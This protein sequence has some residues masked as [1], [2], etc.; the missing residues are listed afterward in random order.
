MS[1]D[2]SRL[3]APRGRTVVAIVVACALGSFAWA[4]PG[5]VRVPLSWP[6]IDIGV[7]GQK[8]ATFAAPQAQWLS[9][10]GEPAIPWH[11]V[12]VLLPP[13]AAI[14]T[15][16][17]EFIDAQQEAIPGTWTV[18]PTPPC[19][20]WKDGAPQIV[21]PDDR[22]LVAGRDSAIYGKSGWWPEEDVRLLTA[23]RMRKWRLV[24]AA[25]PL[26]KYDPTSGALLRCTGGTLVVRFDLLNTIKTLSAVE[27]AERVDSIGEQTVR[28]LALNYADFA[29]TYRVA[30]T[31]R[32]EAAPGYVIITTA[33]IQS[34][35]TKLAD[36]VATKQ[37][38]GFAVSVITETTWGGGTGNTAA[39][40]I[41]T[42]LASHYATDHVEY[43]LL[44]GH[45]HPTTGTVPMKMLWPRQN[46]SSDRESPSDLYYAD[47]TGNWDLDG[48]G[49]YGEFSGDFGAGG[50]DRFWEVIVGRIPN[51]GTISELDGILQK[52]IDYQ[53]QPASATAWRRSALLPMKA[54]DELTPGYPLGEQLKNSILAP[55]GW[56]YHR[57]YDDAYNLVPPPETTPCTRPNVTN[58]WKAG[59]FGL[60]AWWTHGSSTSAT[61]VMDTS[62]AAQLTDD[63]PA[64]AFQGS[65]HNGYPDTSINLAYTLLKKG[66]IST[67]AAS[68]V[69]WYTV[70]ETDYR[71]KPS[72]GGFTYEYA[73][74]LVNENAAAGNA[75][76]DL[77]R[78][79]SP[80][81]RELWMNYTDFNLYGDPAGRMQPRCGRRYVK[82]DAPAG[83][84]G[85]SWPSAYRDLQDALR[86]GAREI[87]VAAGTYKPDRG[88]GTRTAA[89]YLSYETTLYGGFAGTESSLAERNAQYNITILS[90]DLA[91]DDEPNYVNNAENSYNVVICRGAD[92]RTVLDG[93][94]IADG[95]ANGSYWLYMSGAG[96]YVYS[97]S[98]PTVRACR[99]VAN[100]ANSYGAG[101]FN[102]N[103]STPAYSNCTF[104]GNYAGV[105]GGGTS[106]H[107]GSRAVFV[108]CTFTNN[109]SP[110]G[111]GACHISDTGSHTRSVFAG[112]YATNAGGAV[113]CYGT[114]AQFVNCRLVGNSAYSLG[115]AFSNE[116][117][118][119]LFAN[120]LFNGNSARNG[121]GAVYTAGTG[122]NPRFVNCTFT[123]NAATLSNAQGGGIR[124]SDAARVSTSTNCI[125]WNN[126]DRDGTGQS[127]QISNGVPVVNH[128]CVMGWTGSL[129]GVGNFGSDP[130]LADLDGPD[131]LAGTDD[132]DLR[133]RAASPCLDAGDNTALPADALDLDADGD[134]TEPLPLDL[135]DAARCS[136]DPTMPD[137]GNGMPPLVDIGAYE[138]PHQALVVTPPSLAV[139]EGATAAF[140]V[141]IAFDPGQPVVVSIASV[142]GD[143]DIDVQSGA[144]LSFNSA[145]YAVP[146]TVLLA[147]ADDLDNL[148]GTTIFSITADG[149]A[150]ETLIATEQEDDA[151]TNVLYVDANGPGCNN[152]ASWD[153]AYSDLQLALSIAAANPQVTEIRVANGVYRPANVSGN[154]LAT[155]ALQNGLRLRGGYAGYGDAM[156]DARD[157]DSSASVLSGDLAGD[158]DTWFGNRGDNVY[159]VVDASTNDV[160]AVLDGFTIY[161]G[162]AN[163]TAP[164]NVG[165]GVYIDAGSPTLRD[166]MLLRNGGVDG[167]GIM[168]TTGQ[169]L[170]LRCAFVGNWA[171]NNGGGLAFTTLSAPVE[172][173][174]FAGNGAMYGG[175]LYA[176]GACQIVNCAFSGN[177]A[178]AGGGAYLAYADDPG[179]H[180]INC[181]FSR[182]ISGC[183]AYCEWTYTTNCVFWDNAGG[184]EGEREACQINGGYELNY[185]C[186]Q[187]WWPGM[188]GNGNISD[189]PGLVDPDGPDN[190]IGTSD[191]DLRLAAGS[192]CIDA[193][194]N[195]AVPAG[196]T[197]DPDRRPRFVD[198]PAMPNVGSGT[199][200]IVDMGAYEHNPFN[201]ADLN[202]DG[203]VD[204]ADLLLF[205][206][207][208][209]GP[210]VLVTGDCLPRDFSADDDVDLADFALI[211]QALMP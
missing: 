141:R 4:E 119:P 64:M 210:D 159:H 156:P 30:G 165:G 102:D 14:E 42:W 108:D 169:P 91:G 95:N 200:P 121:G 203:V 9:D 100:R 59:A 36:F 28:G 90:G 111:A 112:N 142:S 72:N 62:Y 158:D 168:V 192:P 74:R 172:A 61:D 123:S 23:G 131:G 15:A 155:F 126:R 128:S 149:F 60:V 99:F 32:D 167:A 94:T 194:S 105:Q 139:P 10:V 134:T 6:S 70:G 85:T 197:V 116:A 199:P 103:G 109:T 13:D 45:P 84:D 24:Q 88:T 162:H 16:R 160:T 18:T 152:G 171:D 11:V 129:G 207:C 209:Q 52:T 173:C 163:G 63:Y 187:D 178:N 33:A 38:E 43:V 73:L 186:V 145:N 26:V 176:G 180:L 101:A 104:T 86:D 184:E 68:R 46:A 208:L 143:A 27:L 211:Q 148:V 55:A 2:R 198:D 5:E 188:G 80:P 193:G 41:R 83:G 53:A 136:D 50:G 29:D 71:N 133:L 47:L 196:I 92:E 153:G 140:T 17:V 20:T 150:P 54:L 190:I 157:F 117:A 96:L 185:S 137:T 110:Y 3:T 189:N 120:C 151:V 19:A 35:S 205:A 34:A 56:S 125:F 132:D 166:C 170:L 181:T 25:V 69:S 89:F 76:L 107:A 66:L 195:E 21:W 201:P 44:I 147:A 7:D 97:D 179:S 77:K 87:W 182:N 49:Y 202:F 138:G 177:M 135:D 48:D 67:V 106:S 57:V 31:P 51:Y 161:G 118:T 81:N 22:P 78:A 122:S 65:C 98:G 164:R 40:N 39:E 144:S 183:G 191:D 146:Q 115:G 124:H 82:A 75:L 174:R 37:A 206:Q 58:V 130:R 12:T 8:H 175:G 154:R 204:G 1:R 113:R 93:F 79:M 127:S 114:S